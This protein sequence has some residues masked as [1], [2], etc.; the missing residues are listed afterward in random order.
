MTGAL[1]RYKVLTAGVLSLV[2]ALGVARFAYTPLLP[3][4]QRQAGLGVGAAGWLASINYVGY[5]VGALVAS[6]VGDPALKDRLYRLGL[7]AAVVTTAMMGVSQDPIV[8]AVSRFIA[9][10]GAASCML[11]GTGLVLN[12]LIRHDHRSELGIHFGGV[13]LGIAVTAAAVMAMNRL[14]LDWRAQWWAFTALAVVLTVPA[15]AWMPAPDGSAVTRSGRAM[16]DDPPSPLFLAVF[17]AAYFCAGIGYVVSATF[18]VAIVDR[19]PGV[20]GSGTLVF[21]AIGVGGAPA[22]VIWDLIARRLSD[23]GALTLAGALQI[24]GILL[25]VLSPSLVLALLGA[26]LFGGTVV[27]MVSLVLTMAGRYYP[28]HPAKMMGKMTLSY[29]L[30]QAIAPALTGA[31]AAWFG[32]YRAGL[33]LAAVAMAVGTALLAGLWAVDIRSRRLRPAMAAD[34]EATTGSV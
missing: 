12:W 26:L 2:L 34:G 29:G 15:L 22:C 18:I 3:L 21:L 31:A 20:A 7:I 11:F 23:L 13:G 30:A 33:Y 28:T 16:P 19:L 6:L 8:W 24:V 1:S 14:G 5:L 25:P 4:M 17:L 10:L 9:G 27:G 32:D